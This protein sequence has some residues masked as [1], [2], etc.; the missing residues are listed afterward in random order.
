MLVRSR[1]PKQVRFDTLVRWGKLRLTRALVDGDIAS[2][3]GQVH[4]IAVLM[5]ST[6]SCTATTQP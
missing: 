6:A 2:V 3:A 1:G 4:Q 5:H